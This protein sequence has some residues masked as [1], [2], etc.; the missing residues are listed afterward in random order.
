MAMT[1]GAAATAGAV[2]GGATGVSRAARQG[3]E[4]A[5]AG[6][7]PMDIARASLQGLRT[8]ATDGALDGGGAV[9]RGETLRSIGNQI[10]DRLGT[11]K[12]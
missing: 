7:G 10:R 3:V 1:T 8:G 9:A 2:A 4:A 5:K 6:G 11:P 12:R